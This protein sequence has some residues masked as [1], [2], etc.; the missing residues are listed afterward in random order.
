MGGKEEEVQAKGIR[1]VQQKTSHTLRCK[2]DKAV[3]KSPKPNNT[4]GKK[5][6]IKTK[7]KLLTGAR[8]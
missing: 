5:L 3:K 1:K 6:N 7:V 8:G 4:V 2:A